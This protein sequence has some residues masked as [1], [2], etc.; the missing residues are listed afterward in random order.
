MRQFPRASYVMLMVALFSAPGAAQ[1]ATEGLSRDPRVAWLKENVL[2]IRSINP[3]DQ[4]FRDLEPLRAALEG[5]RLVLLGEADHG[6][7]SDFLAKTRLVKFLHSELGFDVLAF[8]TPMYDMTVV[9]QSLLAGMPPRDA[10]FAGQPR[11]GDA[12]AAPRGVS[13]RASARQTA[14]GDRRLGPS[15]PA[16]QRLPFCG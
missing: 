7:G 3:D 15:T 10:L 4:D 12:N 2:R 6:S 9:W 11:K 13:R 8:E 5:I 16:G 14:V 1:R